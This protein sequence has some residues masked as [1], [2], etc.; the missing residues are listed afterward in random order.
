MTFDGYW[1]GKVAEYAAIRKAGNVQIRYKATR[2]YV[3]CPVNP[4]F[5]KQAKA[6]LGTWRKRSEIWTFDRR[7]EEYIVSLCERLWPGKVSVMGKATK[8]K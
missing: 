8:I 7:L 3:I 2:L 1:M 6:L 4:E 5:I